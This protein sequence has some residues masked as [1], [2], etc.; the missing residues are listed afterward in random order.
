MAAN[1]LHAVYQ[2]YCKSLGIRSLPSQYLVKAMQDAMPQVQADRTKVAGLRA[3]VWKGVPLRPVDE[4]KEVP[5]VPTPTQAPD[6]DV[7]LHNLEF[8]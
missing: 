4:E 3:R 8:A 2:H 7:E 6:L 5:L 1:T